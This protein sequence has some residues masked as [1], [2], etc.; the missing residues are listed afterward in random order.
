MTE[1]HSDNGGEHQAGD[2]ASDWY[3]SGSTAST[4]RLDD[5]LDSNF[6]N[7]FPDDGATATSRRA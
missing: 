7:V 3:E 1:G 5:E 2:L 6:G 4:G